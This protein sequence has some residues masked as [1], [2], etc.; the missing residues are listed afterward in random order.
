MPDSIFSRWRGLFST[1]RGLSAEALAHPEVQFEESDIRGLR[2]FLAGVA[3]LLV[4]WII[5][6]LLYFVFTLL[7]HYRESAAGH[8]PPMA[9]APN[10]L[11]PA[12]R[13]QVRPE[14]DL[15]HLRAY[16]D[17]QL[18]SYGWANRQNGTITI[19]V[20]RAMQ[21]IAGRGIP[22]QKAPADLKLSVPA[23][24][25]RRTGFEGKV[26]PEPQ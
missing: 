22:P 20:D 19:P 12:P 23:A 26:Q 17:S 3:L 15:Q 16:E 2:V 24:G 13:L 1:R 4:L 11:P 14:V 5:V 6:V 9:V 7:V 10:T 25:T 8:T 21:I 18:H